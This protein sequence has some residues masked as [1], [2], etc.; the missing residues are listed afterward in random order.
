M[1]L[2]NKKAFFEDL[3]FDVCENVYEPAEDSFLFADNLN[4]TRGAH[5]LDMGT[6]SGI[7]GILAAKRAGEVVAIDVNPY[8]IRCAKQNSVRNSVC[9]KVFFLQGDLFSSLN[10]T[11]RFDLILFNAPYLPSEQGEEESWLGRA[12]SGGETGR[13]IIDRFI[14]NLAKRLN[15]DGEVLLMQSN[16]ANIEETLQ[17]FNA[18]GMRA[19]TVATLDLPFFET[20]FLLKAK[21]EPSLASNG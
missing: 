7:L 9:D 1:H 13:K 18:C 15:R 12:W 20:L 2:A 21:L 17:R 14:S 16:L 8:A 6:G 3:V 5:V 19:E 11:A 4:V 10:E